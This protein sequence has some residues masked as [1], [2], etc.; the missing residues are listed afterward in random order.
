[1]C[2][3]KDEKTKKNVLS[4]KKRTNRKKNLRK[5]S[6]RQSRKDINKQT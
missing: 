1:M 4:K 2:R 5:T 6:Q 3:W